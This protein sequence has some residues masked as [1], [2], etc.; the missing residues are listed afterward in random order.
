MDSKKCGIL[1][2]EQVPIDDG[3]GQMRIKILVLL[4]LVMMLSSP[5][6]S[7]QKMRVAVMG[8]SNPDPASA[9]LQRFSDRVTQ[10]IMKSLSALGE[11]EVISPNDVEAA[12]RDLLPEYRN[13]DN[14][15]MRA[16]GR[17]LKADIVVN[18]SVSAPGFSTL[19][20]EVRILDVAKS[21]FL[22]TISI[23]NRR[24]MEDIV[25][26][27]VVNR[28]ATET[29]TKFLGKKTN[30][31][32]TTTTVTGAGS[33]S[34]SASSISSSRT[35]SSSS[36][37]ASAQTDG[38][39]P[40]G[41]DVTLNAIFHWGSVLPLFGNESAMMLG[42]DF[43][44][45]LERTY[46]SFGFGFTLAGAET[47]DIGLFF[48]THFFENS[49]WRNWQV[50]LRTGPALAYPLTS[51]AEMAFKLNTGLGVRFAIPYFVFDAGFGIDYYSSQR[52]SL[53][54]RAGG[55]FHF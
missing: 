23:Q 36:S 10:T 53:Y 55:G 45:D 39:Q 32:E 38:L 1:A 11:Y 9:T 26:G 3:A 43:V 13:L 33:S 27:E 2:A 46:Y 51:E 17:R 5:L 6:L 41:R 48:E 7:A 34:S 31:V 14:A 37:S 20:V 49:Y 16:L 22:D 12:R 29:G 4:P 30:L 21:E 19:A 42:V 44:F 28:V 50:Y 15:L 47:I 40:P 25:V 54:I 24:E 18:G 8:F 52:S 35:V